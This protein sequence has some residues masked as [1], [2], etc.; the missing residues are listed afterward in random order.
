MNTET[1]LSPEKIFEKF[2]SYAIFEHLMC[3]NIIMI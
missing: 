1:E 2:F 3:Y